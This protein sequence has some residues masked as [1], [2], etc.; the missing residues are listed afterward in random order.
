VSETGTGGRLK[1]D[2]AQPTNAAQANQPAN[3]PRRYRKTA[4]WGKLSRPTGPVRRLGSDRPSRGKWSQNTSAD[5]VRA[6]PGS[7]VQADSLQGGVEGEHA[8]FPY[9]MKMPTVGRS[10]LEVA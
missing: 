7:A 8:S 4:F 10:D 6:R 5:A 9:G 2:H 1:T 3:S